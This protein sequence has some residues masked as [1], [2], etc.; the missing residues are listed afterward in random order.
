MGCAY[1]GSAIHG[2]DE[3]IRLSDF[4]TG[5]RL[6]A[7]L[8]E[9]M[10]AMDFVAAGRLRADYDL[11]QKRLTEAAGAEPDDLYGLLDTGLPPIDMSEIEAAMAGNDPAPAAKPKGRRKKAKPA[12]DPATGGLP[13]I[14]M[15]AVLAEMAGETHPAPTPLTRRRRKPAPTTDPATGG[16]PDIDMSAVLA[17]MAGETHPAPKPLTRRRR[18]PA[19]T[20]DPATGGL[21]NIDTSAVLAEPAGENTPAPKPPHRRKK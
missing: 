19:P 3:N 6:A 12:P 2:P 17:E 10:A 8:L 11:R 18:K 1:P 7:L 4:R 5:T 9:R 16:L 15:S 14:D 20:A 21:P 13:D